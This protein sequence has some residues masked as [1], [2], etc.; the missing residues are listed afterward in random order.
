M[1]TNIA[2]KLSASVLALTIGTGA[3]AQE[4]ATGAVR[5]GLRARRRTA[6]DADL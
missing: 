3:A 5:A 4:N 6:R 2:T 1:K